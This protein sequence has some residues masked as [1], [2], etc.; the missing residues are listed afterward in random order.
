M[1]GKAN[2]ANVLPL[3]ALAVMRAGVRD[4]ASE[5]EWRIEG[6][7]G[8]VLR[9]QL[10]GAA[11]WWFIY[12]TTI[13]GERK[14]RRIQ[15]G[16]RDGVT[17]A[18]ARKAAIELRRNVVS[19]SDP[20]AEVKAK[21]SALS[22][23]AMT[24]RFIDESPKLSAKTRPVYRA[25]LVKDAYPLI[26]NLPAAEVT[27]AHVLAICQRIEA[28][29]KANGKGTGVQSQRTKTTISGAYSWAVG[30]GWCLRTPASVSLGGP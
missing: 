18:G 28:R 7:R 8:L 11:T 4:G 30:E 20:V 6:E 9:C 24:E 25:A 27:R 16:R 23:Q 1:A 14:I 15:I 26:G 2:A 10:S 3:N 17:L 12:S 13:A 19:G 22:F 5:S 21:R 29:A